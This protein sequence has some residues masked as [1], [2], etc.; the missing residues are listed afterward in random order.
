LDILY[1]NDKII[2][3]KGDKEYMKRE[4]AL[5]ILRKYNENK[6]LIKHGIAVES[7]MRRFAEINNED[8][9]YWGFVGLLHDID[10]GMYPE[11]HC[12]K[13]VDILQ[14]EGFSEDIIRSIQSHG[15]GIC[16]DVKPE[17]FMEKVLYT[18]DELTGLIIATALMKP[19]K[20][21]EEVDLESVK[22]KW[23]KK[24]FAA[25]VDRELIQK[26]A[27]MLGLELDYIIEQTLIGM[28]NKANELGL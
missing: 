8:I 6:N 11:Q 25:G 7:A 18:V 9:E 10:Y 16:V 3:T 4:E 13:C 23:K 1:I 5:E 2:K 12:K 14:Q 22:K 20:T 24:D 19:N 27:D 17:K 21:L 26:G 15:Y 28:K